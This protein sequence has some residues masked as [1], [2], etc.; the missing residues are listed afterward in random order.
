[1]LCVWFLEDTESLLQADL[2]VIPC[3]D[4]DQNNSSGVL[5]VIST[6][7]RE[8]RVSAPR[9]LLRPL[10]APAL[11]VLTASWL[12]ARASNTPHNPD[13]EGL[14]GLHLCVSSYLA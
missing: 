6:T 4:K 5:L 8:S 13:P 12:A 14:H 1:M 9:S 11:V 2:L 7:V 10:L 3:S